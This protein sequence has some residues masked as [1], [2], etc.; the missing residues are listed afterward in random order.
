MA[1]R[2]IDLVVKAH[3]QA[4]RKMG[5]VG[6]ATARLGRRFSMLKLAAAAAAVAIGYKLIRALSRA[7]KSMVETGDQFEK[8]SRATGMSTEMLSGLSHAAKISGADF[9]AI[10]KSMK[11]F[12]GAA[13][14]AGEGLESYKRYFDALGITVTDN[15]GKLKDLN[16]LFLEAAD[17]LAKMENSTQRAALAAKL[18]GRGGL[19]L[20]PM[21]REGT[22]GIRKLMEEAR[23]LGIVWSQED[24]VAA[25]EFQDAVERLRASMRG[26]SKTML[27]QLVPVLEGL[28]NW[29]TEN[30]QRMQ[31]NIGKV[32]SWWKARQVDLVLLLL[33]FKKHWLQFCYDLVAGWRFTQTAIVSLSL[34]TAKAVAQINAAMLDSYQAFTDA[35]A[36]AMFVAYQKA[37]GK[38]VEEALELYEAVMPKATHRWGDMFRAEVDKIRSASTKFWDEWYAKQKGSTSALE[39]QLRELA[40]TQRVILMAALR[41]ITGFK[42][43][44][45]PDVPPADEGDGAAARAQ[46]RGVRAYEA[47]FMRRAPGADPARQTATNTAKMAKNTEEM[48]REQKMTR[49]EFEEIRRRGQHLLTADIAG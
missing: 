3:D 8:F 11:T 42:L 41:D 22:A 29:V 13:F 21:L 38:T 24:T 49:E 4:S 28:A 19:T 33:E 23:E 9:G 32:F 6:K 25:A 17:G 37:K 31:E 18:F 1:K 39:K 44:K 27:I 30:L 16:D 48:I 5:G 34:D 47:R 10:Q 26:L 15:S 7:F 2:S 14:E 40:K 45:I 12:S 35:W 43:A 20:M 36:T 46:R